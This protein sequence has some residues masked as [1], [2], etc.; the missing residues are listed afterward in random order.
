MAPLA[1]SSSQLQQLLE[2][3]G[4]SLPVQQIYVAQSRF[5]GKKTEARHGQLKD[6]SYRETLQR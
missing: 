6:R 4:V 2:R 3:N 1:P 5:T